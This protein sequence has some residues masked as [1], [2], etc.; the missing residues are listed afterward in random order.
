[1]IDSKKMIEHK[2]KIEHSLSLLEKSGIAEKYPDEEH[3]N[4]Y[5][6]ALVEQVV[7]RLATL[8]VSNRGNRTVACTKL[9]FEKIAKGKKNAQS[10]EKLEYHVYV[11]HYL[12]FR[13]EPSEKDT[14]K[15]N[16]PKDKCDTIC[17]LCFDETCPAKDIEI[18]KQM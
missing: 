12:A 18:E 11:L 9:V 7:K 5:K 14:E 10:L 8:V 2:A 1:M 13:E 4:E 15:Q 16:S 3:P 17:E 6:F